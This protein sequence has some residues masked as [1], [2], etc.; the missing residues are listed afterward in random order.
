MAGLQVF[1][2]ALLNGNRI[3][4]LFN[5]SH[6]QLLKEIKEYKVTHISATPTF[7]RLLLPSED[8]FPSV[9]RVTSGG[10]RFDPKI[11]RQLEPVFP[12]ARIT[13][14]YAS[15]EAGTLFAA[16]DETFT[17]KPMMQEWMKI[18]NNELFIHE[19]LLGEADFKKQEWFATGDLVEIVGT[20]PIKFR[21]QGR[22][23]ELINVGGY[24]VNPHE[25]EEAIR[26]IPGIIDVL[27]YAKPNSVI[28]NIICCEAIRSDSI[29]D[30]TTI[31]SHLQTKLQEFKIPR[32]IKFVSELSTTHTGK[33]RRKER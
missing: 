4:R 26:S 14:V 1:F 17:I 18:E 3:I 24:M 20:N 19:S 15:T 12:Q 13:N 6:E 2:Q 5:L 22:R 8:T 21:I 25:V 29:L 23:N 10:E 31:R 32:T 7:F 11:I 28:G 30:E 27:I 33:L 16:K 9:V